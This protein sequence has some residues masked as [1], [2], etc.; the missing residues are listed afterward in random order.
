MAEKHQRLNLLGFSSSNLRAIPSLQIRI[1]A[2]T[3]AASASLLYKRFM[4]S[5]DT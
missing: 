4:R 1:G 3:G 5:M 2:Q